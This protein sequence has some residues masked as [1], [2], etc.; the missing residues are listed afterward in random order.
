MTRR[1]ALALLV[2]V[3]GLALGA[4]PVTLDG[5]V[6]DALVPRLA[7]APD[8]SVHLVYQGALGGAGVIVH[9]VWSEGAW[10]PEAIL[11]TSEGDQFDPA[12]AVGSDGTVHVVWS[13]EI[14]GRLA[15]A[16][17]ARRGPQWG[18]MAILDPSS[19]A[20]SEFPA[21]AA[22]PDGGAE[23][24]WQAGEGARYTVM[25]ASVSPAGET[26]AAAPVAGQSPDGFNISPQVFLTPVPV[27]TWYEA[28]DGAFVLRA[29]EWI[30]GPAWRGLPLEDL[31][32]IDTRRV[33]AL[34]LSVAGRWAALWCD[35]AA[36]PQA[37]SAHERV[38]L[39]LG[40]EPDWGLGQI[41]DSNPDF[42]NRAPSAAVSDR[43]RWAVAWRGETPWGPEI[44]LATGEGGEWRQVMLTA[45]QTPAAGQPAVCWAEGRV[46]V[47]WTSLTREGGTGRLSH[48]AVDVP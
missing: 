28:S 43:G 35:V 19:R 18:P 23:V 38:I 44:Y 40:G 46:H 17:R 9:R 21:V 11:S 48:L 25:H 13:A 42:D 37:A 16:H 5:V 24:V 34:L 32:L 1:I 2:A 12:L 30:P 47:V 29:A 26:G 36:L 14:G 7:A 41:V 33:P 22:R 31:L 39:G 10:G 27:V 3:T 15:I 6:G 45:G 4:Q 8:G 20:Q